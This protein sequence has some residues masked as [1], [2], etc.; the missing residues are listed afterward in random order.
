[1]RSNFHTLRT[2]LRLATQDY[3]KLKREEEA[4]AEAELSEADKSLNEFLALP[5][6]IGELA[7]SDIVTARMQRHIEALL[8]DR[9][10]KC[11][12]DGKPFDADAELPNVMRNVLAAATAQQKATLSTGEADARFVVR[13]DGRDFLR[14]AQDVGAVFRTTAHVIATYGQRLAAARAARGGDR[15]SYDDAVSADGDASDMA[16]QAARQALEVG[17]NPAVMVGGANLMHVAAAAGC[18]RAVALLALS[19]TPFGQVATGRSAPDG[20]G[21]HWMPIELAAGAGHAHVVR[22]LV[23]HGSAFGSA[24]QVAATCGALDVLKVLFASGAAN[25]DAR[26]FGPSRLSCAEAAALAGQERTFAWLCTE[27]LALDTLRARRVLHRRPVEQLGLPQ[28]STLLHALCRLGGV[29]T[30]RIVAL[31]LRTKA[32]AAMAECR[33]IDGKLPIEVASVAIA[34]LLDPERLAALALLTADDAVRTARPSTW[35]PLLRDGGASLDAQDVRGVSPLIAAAVLGDVAGLQALLDAGAAPPPAVPMPLATSGGAT[36]GAWAQYASTDAL[37]LLQRRNARLAVADAR[38][39]SRLRDAMQRFGADADAVAVLA[40]LSAGSLPLYAPADE[41]GALPPS[42]RGIVARFVGAP[43]AALA[44]V[45]VPSARPDISAMHFLASRAT[46]IDA[47]AGGVD[48]GNAPWKRVQRAACFFAQVRTRTA[49][50]RVFLVAV[51]HR[52][53]PARTHSVALRPASSRCRRRAWRRC[54]RTRCTRQS[55]PWCTRRSTTRR[56]SGRRFSTTFTRRSRAC[57]CAAPCSFARCACRATSW[58]TFSRT[59]SATPSC[60]GRTTR[61]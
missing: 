54:T 25:G 34:P 61:R 53:P 29:E 13:L 21:R 5:G 47:A 37:A 42:A 39:T 38:A 14:R 45:Q 50:E 31:L 44:T 33:D 27:K 41:T 2:Y 24:L 56:T 35:A 20:S 17:L 4:E 26:S 30:V 19:G 58:P 1:M 16:L 48:F 22:W 15:G 6:V 49:L 18:V 28:D 7:R 57:R 3:L 12:A 55:P 51:S 23:E 60:S 8:E 52:R 9:Q 40:S 32:G 11:E 10:A 46:P 43:R 59:M 36:A